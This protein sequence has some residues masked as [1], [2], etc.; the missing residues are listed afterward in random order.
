[1]LGML[2]P[3]ILMAHAVELSGEKP[4]TANVPTFV[5]SALGEEYG[6]GMFYLA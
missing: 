2:L 4:T 1:M 6:R 5:A 3:T